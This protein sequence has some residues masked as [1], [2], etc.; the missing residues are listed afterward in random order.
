MSFPW[1]KDQTAALAAS[2]ASGHVPHALLIHD[3]PGAG[4]DW[5]ALW[6]AQ[7]MYCTA[8]QAKPCG[9]CVM[10][11]RVAE[12]MHPDVLQVRP[13]EDSRQIRID[14]VRELCNELAL[15]SHG[16]GHRVGIVSPADCM[17]PF[18]ANALLKT[19]EEPPGRTLLILVAVQPSRL[20]ATILSRCQR[21]RIRPPT[22]DQSL[23]W[24]QEKRGAGDWG[25]V[26][27]VIGEAPLLAAEL[28]PGAVASVRSE[29]QKT[30]TDAVGGRVDPVGTAAR[31]SRSELP[32]RLTCIENWITERIR[33]G[34][35]ASPDFV[36][37]R[38]GAHL[39]A[40]DSV[41]NIR[42]LFELLD[43]VRELKVLLDTGINSALALESLLRTLRT[44]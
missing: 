42:S 7:L 6:T 21:I 39:P 16:G 27:D 18:A 20:P 22:R 15:T 1:L 28:D 31:W 8:E 25:A 36:E 44:A 9:A 14:Q 26:L 37:M 23:A 12:G 13:T 38:S 41:M 19:L 3:T 10:C 30:L 29:T 40:A 17:N 33:R 24:L 35:G 5:L 43:R 32:L 4:G 2:Q 11:R 34:L